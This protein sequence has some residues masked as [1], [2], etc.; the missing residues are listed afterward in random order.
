MSTLPA[1]L[2]TVSS[3]EFMLGTRVMLHSFLAANPWFDGE[4]VVLHARLES[5]ET[6]L[7]QSGFQRLSC[8]TAGPGL[9][10]AVDR[11]IEAFPKLADR[12]DRFLSLETLLLPGAWPRL[13]IDSDVVVCGDLSPVLGTPGALVACPDATMLR[14][15]ERDTATFAEVERGEAARPSFNAGMMLVRKAGADP[16]GL[17]DPA[18]WAAIASDHTDQAVWNLL[19]RDHVSLVGPEFNFMVGHAGL[20]GDVPASVRLYHF[21]GRAKPWL[22]DRQAQAAAQGGITGT[23]FAAWRE[24]CKAMLAAA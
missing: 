23:A 7:L 18:A 10:G 11:L 12:R 8:R 15:R 1:Q 4:I 14:G 21:N 17:L 13:F 6:D 24:A 20:Y 5:H 16:L 2:V 22:A 3:P 19:Y 9:G